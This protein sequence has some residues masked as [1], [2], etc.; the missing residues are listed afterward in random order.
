MSEV[1]HFK[2]PS[3]GAYLEYQPNQQALICPY[4]ANKV[5]LEAVQ[6]AEQT[7]VEA[8]PETYTPG[9]LKEYHCQSCGAQIVTGD[10]TAATRCYF[11]HSP[12]VL[13]DRLSG[14]FKPDW[15]IP[16]AIDREQ[17]E[18]HFSKYLA[19]KRFVDKRV[20][21]REQREMFSG[22]YYPYWIG[23]IEGEAALSG[24]GVRTSSSVQG[25]YMV[26]VHRFYHVEREGTLTFRNLF[27]KA[28]KA[29]DRQLTDGIQPYTLSAMKPFDPAYLSGFLAEMRD[30]EEQSA[31]EDMQQEVERYAKPMMME[32]VRSENVNGTFS[33]RPVRT[34]MRYVL[35]PA[36]VL[37][38]QSQGKSYYYLM[39]AQTGTVCGRLPFNTGKLIGTALAVGAAV[40]GLLC[41]GGAFIW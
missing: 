9:Q 1:K 18:Q 19:R 29:N 25:N 22:V 15:V 33:F 36:W 39:N 11:C 14:S 4:C 6:P 37:T 8:K 40:A 12:V 5:D 32:G 3:C 28:L 34:R 17:A 10:T 27:R 7:S 2:C 13:T 35:L 26:T 38:Y 20:F 24:D 23:E 41:A 16:F 21:T 30:V 31:A